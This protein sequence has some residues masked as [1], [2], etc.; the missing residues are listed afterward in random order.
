M[1]KKNEN[2]KQKGLE[3]YDKTVE[4]LA[5]D[6]INECK[7]R[8]GGT[9]YYCYCVDH[10]SREDLHLQIIKQFDPVFDKQGNI[11]LVPSGKYEARITKFESVD[12]NFG[13]VR[14]IQCENIQ[15]AAYCLRL[16]LRIY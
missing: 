8:R 10:H 4:Q 12:H 5:D 9:G 7:T 1:A 13:T 2:L 15:D 6:I 3:A 16:F 14:T 11:T